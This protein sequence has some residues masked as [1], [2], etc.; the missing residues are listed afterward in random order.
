MV[1]ILMR[2]DIEIATL[3]NGMKLMMQLSN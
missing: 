3:T 2:L 1:G